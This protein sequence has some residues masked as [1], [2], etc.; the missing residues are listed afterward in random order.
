MIVVGLLPI[1]N[2]RQQGLTGDYR[3]RCTDRFV[4]SA[5]FAQCAFGSPLLLAE[6]SSNQCLNTSRNT[7]SVV[8]DAIIN[9]FLGTKM[10][11]N[12]V[13]QTIEQIKAVANAISLLNVSTPTLLLSTFYCLRRETNWRELELATISHH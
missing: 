6:H 10:S 9:A 12:A 8:S 7:R 13:W 3:Y 5:R 11:F 1:V 2:C 4:L